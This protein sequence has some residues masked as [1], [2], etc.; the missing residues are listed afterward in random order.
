MTHFPLSGRIGRIVE[1]DA[2]N[3]DLQ[4][5]LDLFLD[6]STAV[7]MGERKAAVNFRLRQILRGEEVVE[8]FLRIDDAGVLVAKSESAIVKILLDGIEQVGNAA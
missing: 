1:G 5:V 2:P 6:G 4:I 7:P 8:F 3:G